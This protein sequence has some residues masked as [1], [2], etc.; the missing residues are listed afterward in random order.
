MKVI[1]NDAEV[2]E[3][4]LK[5]LQEERYSLKT[6]LGWIDHLQID[7]EKAK[8]EHSNRMGRVSKKAE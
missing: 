3:W 6:E 2:N 7:L 5:F 8:K 1:L 4:V